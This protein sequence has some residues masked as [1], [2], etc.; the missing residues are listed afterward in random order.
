MKFAELSMVTK[1]LKNMFSEIKFRYCSDN[2]I[3]S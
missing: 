2:F 1:Y 3:I